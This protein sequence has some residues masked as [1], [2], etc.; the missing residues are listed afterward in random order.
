VISL[1]IDN[2]TPNIIKVSSLSKEFKLYKNKGFFKREV[3]KVEAVKN[4]SF[5]VKEGEIL[6]FIG[7]NGAGKSTT[8]KMM[9][10]ILQPTSGDISVMGLNP[11]KDRKKL[12]YKI[13]TVFGQKSQLWFHLPPIDS[14]HLLGGIY[15]IPSGT[16]KLRINY[17]CDMMEINELMNIPVRKLSLGQRIKCEI[18]ASLLHSPRVIFLDEP[19]IGLDVIAKKN[20]RSLIQRINEEEKTTIF[21]TSH[22]MGD[23]EKL[24]KRMIIINCG[25]ILLDQNVK[26]LKYS[27]DNKKIISIRY[28]DPVELDFSDTLSGISIPTKTQFAARV[29]VDTN[30]IDIEDV[31]SKLFKAGKVEDISIS[32]RPLE[33]IIAEIYNHKEVVLNG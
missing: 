5:D 18:A 22:D 4:I 13:G 28:T 8:I 7:P 1:N 11:Q 9:T 21:L 19:T 24:C 6:A 31:V 16:L 2:N 32:S 29:E 26:S 23:I 17:L 10:G 27:Y 30:R 3:S 15:D 12:A 20:L 25:A 14:F 33:D